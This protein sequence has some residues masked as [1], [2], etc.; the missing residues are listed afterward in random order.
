[1]VDQVLPLFKKKHIRLGHAGIAGFRLIYRYR[2][3]KKL[4]RE[5][6]DTNN[7]KQKGI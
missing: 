6:M 4:E 3:K 5:G 7:K 2:I 1:M